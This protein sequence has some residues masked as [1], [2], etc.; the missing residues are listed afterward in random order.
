MHPALASRVQPG[1]V[2][3]TVMDHDISSATSLVGDVFA[4]RIDDG[5]VRNGMMIIPPGSKIVGAVTAVTPAKNMRGGLPG[6]LQVTLQA[7]VL[8]DGQHVPLHGFIDSNPNHVFKQPQKVRYP[9][10]DLRDYGQQV[11]G[12]M[13]SYTSGLGNVLAKRHRGLEFVLEKGELVPVRLNRTLV[14]PESVVR[15]VTAE[16]LRTAAGSNGQV[17]SAGSGSRLNNV[18]PPQPQPVP[19]LVDSGMPPVA[20][21]LPSGAPRPNGVPSNAVPQTS[22]STFPGFT[23]ATGST[24]LPSVGAAPAVPGLEPD[25]FQQDLKQS[26]AN[27]VLKDMPDPF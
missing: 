26:A 25:I 15:P 16:D 17:G 8:P 3:T 21:S 20:P 10:S 11:T 24:G 18:Q 22:P 19:G 9:G 5:Y 7:L 6:A 1:V 2:L 27:S 4:L 14:V 12:M 23:A 13:Q